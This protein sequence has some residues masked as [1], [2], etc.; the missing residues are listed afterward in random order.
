MY[1]IFSAN[2]RFTENLYANHLDAFK[3]FRE[4]KM[5][6]LAFIVRE[7]DNVIVYDAISDGVDSW[8]YTHNEKSPATAK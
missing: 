5:I 4:S 2:G 6:G 7:Y 8:C 3:A 1:S